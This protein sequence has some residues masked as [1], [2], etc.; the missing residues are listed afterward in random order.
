[1]R[2]FAWLPR[3]SLSGTDDDIVALFERIVYRVALI[4]CAGAYRETQKGGG[5]IGVGG[6]YFRKINSFYEILNKMSPGRGEG[7]PFG[8]FC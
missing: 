4:M 8:T 5:E 1:M 3:Y 2:T 6:E 7:P